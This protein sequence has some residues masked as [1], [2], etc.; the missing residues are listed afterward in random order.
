[1]AT[2]FSKRHK[3]GG[4]GLK[5]LLLV[6]LILLF[7]VPQGMILSLVNE[8]GRLQ[9][10]AVLG[11][12]QPLGGQPAYTGPFLAVPAIARDK[13]DKGNEI[14]RNYTV[15]FA[16]ENGTA[17]IQA[18]V[19]SLQ[20]GIYQAPVVTMQASLGFAFNLGG[21]QLE[22]LGSDEVLWPK[23]E[24]LIAIPDARLLASEAILSS[25][26]G[27]EQRLKGGD[28]PVPGFHRGLTTPVT[29]VAGQVFAGRVDFTLR[30][31]GSLQL[32]PGGGD[33]TVNLTADW[34]SPSFN[35]FVL[36]ASREL[37]EDGFDATWF[38]PESVQPLNALFIGETAFSAVSETTFGVEFLEPVDANRKAYRAAK[39][40]IL[41]IAA[42][43]AVLF[44]F[45]LFAGLRFHP[46]QYCL[47]GFANM[48]FYLLLLSISEHWGF[49]PAYLSAALLTS[50]AVGLY[51]RSISQGHKAWWAGL[52][53]M[54]AL[55]GLLYA[56]L[57]SEDY[58]LLIG[59]LCLFAVSAGVMWATRK[60]D[61]YG[62]AAPVV[63]PEEPSETAAEPTGTASPQL[64]SSSQT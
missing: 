28:S 23:A 59:S 34:P 14:S 54:V 52:A 7:L 58:A 32:A 63:L 19:D 56:M 51:F 29:V 5:L 20:R 57:L 39:Y 55:Y 2:I 62:G 45:E 48:V 37:R 38:L 4:F 26:S 60:V 53:S 6:V 24:L 43:F 36:P 47:I 27:G 44:L 31:G 35:G 10:E 13:D 9:E 21:P 42:P 50:L 3:V 1:M 46:V 49:A 18:T 17:D 22:R 41:F 16:P 40:A 11:M 25:E 64:P 30:G 15:Y 12:Y 33:V 8:R 61:W